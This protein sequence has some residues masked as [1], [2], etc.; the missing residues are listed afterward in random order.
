MIS[1]TSLSSYLYCQR[2]LFL[3][4]VLG[5]FEIPKAALIKGTVRHET[6]DLINK[7]EED[8]VK[9]IIKKTSFDEL[10]QKYKREYEKLLRQ[11]VIKNKFKIQKVDLLPLDLFEKVLP[12]IRAE[13]EI[14]AD[15]IYTFISKH[16]VFGVEL[17]DKLTPKIISEQ[18]IDSQTLSLK[19]I[20]VW[21][22]WHTPAFG[23]HIPCP[24]LK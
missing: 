5:L 4:R 2:K 7:S 10:K 3:E 6:Y 20:I 16:N 21:S 17:W 22:N 11:V 12:M 15:K 14:R 1:V 23:E 18:R 9:S 24:F 13:A 19:G 8:F